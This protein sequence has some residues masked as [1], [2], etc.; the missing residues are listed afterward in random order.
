M[1]CVIF[2]FEVWDEDK[3]GSR[4]MKDHELQGVA[5]F[6]L[7]ELM[8]SKQGALTK[9]LSRALISCPASSF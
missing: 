6:S 3:K 9:G 1:R 4:D 5:T 8:A 2:L 7:G